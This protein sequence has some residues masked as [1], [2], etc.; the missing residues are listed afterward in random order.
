[1]TFEDFYELYKNDKKS[2]VKENTWLTKEY[3]INLKILPY[4]QKER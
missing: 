3:I 4:L 2:R 1:M